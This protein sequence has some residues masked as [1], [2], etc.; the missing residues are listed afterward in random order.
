MKNK[1]SVLFL[2]GLAATSN[3]NRLQLTKETIATRLE[4]TKDKLAHI[5]ENTKGSQIKNKLDG[6]FGKE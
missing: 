2:A 1:L 3:G 4:G 6:L 5:K